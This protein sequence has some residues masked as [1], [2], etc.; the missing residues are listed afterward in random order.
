MSAFL[1]YLYKDTLPASI[2][3]DLIFGL[4]YLADKYNVIRLKLELESLA[5]SMVSSE[6]AASVLMLADR[7][8]IKGLS[9]FT[10][11][12]I[13]SNMAEVM[14]TEAWK[15]MVKKRPQLMENILANIASKL[16]MKSNNTG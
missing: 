5:S 9:E 11:D 12:H 7:H 3:I 15:E 10:V 4:L 2:D 13:L 8:S 6:N 1:E 14:G 16:S